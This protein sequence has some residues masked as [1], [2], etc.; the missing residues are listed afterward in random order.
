[1]W[2]NRYVLKGSKRE[3]LVIFSLL[4]VIAGAVGIALETERQERDTAFEA[5]S[6]DLSASLEALSSRLTLLSNIGVLKSTLITRSGQQAENLLNQSIYNE[7]NLSDI[8]L[9]DKNMKVLAKNTENAG[10]IYIGRISEFSNINWEFAALR[11]VRTNKFGEFGVFSNNKARVLY[12][13][14]IISKNDTRLGSLTAVYRYGDFMDALRIKHAIPSGVNIAFSEATSEGLDHF[15]PLED[16]ISGYGVNF[17]MSY[18]TILSWAKWAIFKALGISI[19][20]SGLMFFIFYLI[21]QKLV[22]PMEYFSALVEHLNRDPS[23]KE[24]VEQIPVPK[25]ILP[26]LPKLQSLMKAIIRSS[27]VDLARQVA[28]DIRSPLAALNVVLSSVGKLDEETRLLVRHSITRIQDIA[29]NLLEKSREGSTALQEA[30]NKKDVHLVSS[31]IEGIVT[32]KRTQYRGRIGV[33][34]VHRQCDSSYG[35]F[36]EIIPSEFKRVL[37][38]LVNNS[39]EAMTKDGTVTISTEIESDFAKITVAD[40]GKGLSK[41]D[42]AKIGSL[43]F[44]VKAEGSG[45]GLGHAL[46]TIEDW[47]GRLTF[48]SEL[49]IGTTVTVYLPLSESPAWFVGELKVSEGMTIAILD[50][51]ASVHQIWDRRLQSLGVQAVHFSTPEQLSQWLL[52]NEK[53]PTRFLVDYELIGFTETGLDLISQLRIS[54]RSILVTSRFEE[55]GIRKKCAELRVPLIPKGLA[56]FIPIKMIEMVDAILIDNEELIHDAWKLKAESVGKNL[57]CFKSSSDFF[58][59][60]AAIDCNTPVYVDLNLEHENGIEVSRRIKDRGFN[61]VYLAT[62]THVS[63][64]RDKDL[65]FL[66]GVLGKSPPW[67]S[68][69]TV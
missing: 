47:G 9:V 16:A 17:S 38:N 37:S 63:D 5:Y 7:E 25:E 50:D 22:L 27:S 54:D 15:K 45:L 41:E 56:G 30:T 64:L 57:L 66:S 52:D 58:S 60:S 49:G 43:G 3:R 13:S 28:H 20:L 14:K 48:E 62:G 18:A 51:D 42:T 31:L 40:T 1:M 11:N 2:F 67:A 33:E 61:C 6:Q 24:G 44:T 26:V 39:V 69:K 12:V 32:E 59:T 65:Q 53:T 29:N 4:F 34:I 35:I 10:G 46:K 21:N 8:F 55:D 19:L 36:C 23:D 68:E